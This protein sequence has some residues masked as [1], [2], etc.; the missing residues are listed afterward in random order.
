MQARELLAAEFVL[1][2]LDAA[3]RAEAERLYAADPAFRREVAWWREKLAPLDADGAE[4]APAHLRDAVMARIGNPPAA[5]NDSTAALRGRIAFW[6]GGAIAAGLAALVVAGAALYDAPKPGERY[7]AMVS[8]S[9]DG[10]AMIVDIDTAAGTV[11]IRP[12][13]LAAHPG[14]SLELWYVGEGAAPRSLG[15]IDRDAPFTIPAGGLAAAESGVIA[16]SLE[17]Q[18]GSPS[19]APTGEVVYSGRL[20]R[21]R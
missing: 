9:G 5:S 12:L 18:G 1:G 4:P 8:H 14:K 6:R 20:I 21:Q 7:V 15:L 13:A 16:V 3:E 2:T 11:E 10:P 17:P 19:G